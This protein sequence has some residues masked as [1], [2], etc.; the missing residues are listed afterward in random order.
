M[1]KILS[2]V[3][4]AI[5]L[6]C[7]CSF[8]AFAAEG[9]VAFVGWNGSDS[10]DGLTP[11]TPKKSW[12]TFEDVGVMSLL[13]NGGTLVAVQKAYLGASYSLPAMS[14]PL[15]ITAVHDGVDYRNAEKADNPDSGVFKMASGATLTLNSDV[16]FDNIILFQENVQNTIVV[17]LGVTLTITDTVDLLTKPGNDYH[18]AIKVEM[19]GTAILSKAAQETC[20]IE[21]LGGTVKTYG[22]EAA[23]GVELKMTL[24]KTDYLLNGEKKTMDVAPIIANNRTMLPV[25]YVAEA[26]GA[27]IAWDGA[28]STATLTTADTEI[29]IT[30]G[31]SEAVVNGQAVKLDS[32]A[33]IENSRTYMPVRFVAETLGATVAWDAATSTATIT[34]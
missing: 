14:A 8:S 32:P 7:V 5:L 4:A 31:A 24:G 30:V 28:T 27:A 10:N 12:K 26:L 16:I 33:F 3:L 22:G 17:P 19:G 34:K 1:K 11:A 18:F 25:R 6:A 21:N 13:Q 29:K 15:T 20:T 2:I 9:T 23:T